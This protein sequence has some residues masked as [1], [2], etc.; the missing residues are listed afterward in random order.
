[1]G[2]VPE[3]PVVKRNSKMIFCAGDLSGACHGMFQPW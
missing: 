2:R 3:A 1:M